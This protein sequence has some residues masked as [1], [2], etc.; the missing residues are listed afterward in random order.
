MAM[1]PET[2]RKVKDALVRRDGKQCQLCGMYLSRSKRTID[3]ITPRCEG[4][5]DELTNLRLACASCNHGR[6]HPPKQR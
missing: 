4:G 3:H 6:H 2:K 1:S 5:L